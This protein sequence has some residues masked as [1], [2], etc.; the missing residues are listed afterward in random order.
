[1]ES[2]SNSSNT[3]NSSTLH[4]LYLGVGESTKELIRQCFSDINEQICDTQTDF[5]ALSEAS[6]KPAF[7]LV[8][9]SSEFAEELRMNMIE[10][11]QSLRMVFTSTPVFYVTTKSESLD[12]S[13]AIKN[14]FA[15]A[16][17]LPIDNVYFAE[18]MAKAA[19]E[20]K[21]KVFSAVKLVDIEP[22]TRL[23][24]QISVFLPANNRYV[25]FSG[26][27]DTM[28]PQRLARLRAKSIKSI[29]IPT[30]QLGA[31]HKY[32]AERLNQLTG[33]DNNLSETER[34]SR[35]RDSVREL[36]IGMLSESFS[37]HISR[38]REVVE[39]SRII[40]NQFIMLKKPA[41]WYTRLENE[42]GKKGDSYSHSGSVSTY[43]TL[44]SLL[45]KDIPP[46]EIAV[47]G[48]FHDLGIAKL[49]TEI[50]TKKVEAL[51]KSEF[52]KYI[53]HPLLSAQIVRDRKLVLPD[54][55][56]KAIEQHHERWN[57]SGY[58]NGVAE[59]KFRHEGQ[60]LAIADQFDYLTRVEQSVS[61]MSPDQA[62]QQL[63]KLKVADPA[64]L[65][66]LIMMFDKK[67]A[68]A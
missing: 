37:K 39:H 54:M 8:I 62:F 43:A 2:N 40:V 42:I 4:V 51:D 61:P 38:G 22:G 49:P 50:Q 21:H 55:I 1:M 25:T 44:F 56:Y 60:I 48:L 18:T 65:R 41:D 3:F 63:E 34:Q 10:L 45:I 26:A 68:A 66:E 11:A 5:E 6:E 67:K 53:E 58:P 64:L 17:V 47:A 59:R 33:S 35:L 9:A 29:Y 36:T 14:G 12:R 20:V 52:E 7:H 46:E 32:S 23:D 15:E 19:R 13:L 28:D 24:F 27:G 31:F 57:G 16:F 30:H